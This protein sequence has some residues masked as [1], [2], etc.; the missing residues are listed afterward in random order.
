MCSGEDH[1]RVDERTPAEV[2]TARTAVSGLSSALTYHP[3]YPR[4]LA[5]L[6][7]VAAVDELETDAIKI[8]Y[9]TLCGNCWNLLFRRR[10]YILVLTAL[11]QGIVALIKLNPTEQR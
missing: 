10:Y 8:T 2:G 6:R 11:Q 1:L 5:I 3:Y 4:E 9:S 7:I